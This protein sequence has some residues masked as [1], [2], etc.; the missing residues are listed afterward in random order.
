MITYCTNVHPGESWDETVANLKTYIPAVKQSASPDEQ[1]PV[2]LRLSN[3]AAAEADSASSE[4]FLD[5]CRTHG[6]YI[7]TIN[8]FPYG[9]FHAGSVRE[10]VYLPDW[11]SAGRAAYTEKLGSLLDAWL[12]AG[13]AGSIST[14]PV[15]FRRHIG[16]DDFGIIK[17]NLLHTLEH[18]DTLGQKSGRSIILALEPE[19]GC[20]LETSEDLICFLERMKFPP[21]LR[22]YIGICYDCCHHAVAFEDPVASLARLEGAGVPVG[23]VQVSSALKFCAPDKETLERFCEP[24]YLHQVVVRT[25]DGAFVHYDDLRDALDSHPFDRD[26]EQ[27]RVHFHVPV[28]MMRLGQYETTSDFAGRIIAGVRT[29]VLLEVETYT[30]YVLPPELRL[31]SITESIIR[32]MKWVKSRVYEKDSCS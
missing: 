22:Q 16:T 11:R 31:G 21:G 7:A 29:N 26:G 15:G 1:F 18:L 2:G 8:G 24:E 28:F 5:W 23:K 20:V 25:R 9:E 6:C 19:P 17:K 32:E 13:T 30:W 27:W 4:G 10:N 14:V 12:P 3:R